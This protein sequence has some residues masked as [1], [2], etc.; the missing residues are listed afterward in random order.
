MKKPEK[1]ECQISIFDLEYYKSEWDVGKK[2]PNLWEHANEKAVSKKSE[3]K[4]KLSIMELFWCVHM[5]SF[6]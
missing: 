1:K 3:K 5:V 2:L 4:E 6:D